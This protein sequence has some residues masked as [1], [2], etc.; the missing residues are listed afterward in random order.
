MTSGDSRE[1]ALRPAPSD[2]RRAGRTVLFAARSATALHRLLDTLPVFAGDDRIARRFTLVPGSDFDAEALAAVER[3]G[4]RTLPWER[5]R[6]GSFDL[7]VAASPKGELRALRGALALLPH[8]AGFGKSLPGEGT[9]GAPSG[10]DP[11]FLLTGGTTLATRHA[12]AHPDQ[13][14]RL[15]GT[16]PRAAAHAVVVGDPT[17]ER[18]LAAVG[19]RDRYRAALGTGARRLVVLTSTWGPESLLRQ[20]PDLVTE[21][22]ALL[23]YDG[24]QLALV[25]HPNERSRRG[26]YD[27]EQ[28]LGPALDAGLVLPGPHAEWATLLVAADA[29]V[30]DHGSTALYAAALGRR[31]VTAYDGG[32]ELLADSPTGQL[33][34]AS[35]RLTAADALPGVLD[36]VLAA[37]RAP[38]ALAAAD[39]AFAHRGRAL[40]LLRDELYGL[41]GLAPTGPAP[42]PEPLPVPARPPRQPAAFLVEAELAGDRVT[43]A[44]FPPWR[45]RPARFLAAEQGVAGER[46]AQSAGLLYRRRSDHQGGAHRVAWTATGWIDAALRDHPGC[47]TAGV[48]L[49]QTRALLRRRGGPPLVLELAPRPC[50]GRLIHT[51]PAAALCAAH[52]WL[53]ATPGAPATFTA[54]IGGHTFPVTLRPATPAEAEQLL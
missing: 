14:T 52:V 21:L 49:S 12:L 43:V 50:A 1:S 7:I 16:S 53:A 27:L 25:T 45:T 22:L 8:G 38:A 19:H 3:A 9:P 30:T 46:H 31:V 10:L 4:A 41:L 47:A 28:G 40:E 5:A 48:L 36:R 23:G 18:L 29:V 20:R 34:A 35:P 33:L 26:S 6:A 44:R 39:A 32:D 11:A 51:D 37:P 42:S 17:L 15:A 13:L 54:D 2:N 24:Y